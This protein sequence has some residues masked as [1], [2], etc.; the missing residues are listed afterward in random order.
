MKSVVLAAAILCIVAAIAFGVR[1][2]V[3]VNRVSAHAEFEIIQLSSALESYKVD[4]GRYPTDLSTE[5]LNP[6]A[7]YNPAAYAETSAFLYRSLS[8]LD[9]A[10]AAD[11]TASS[12]KNYIPD[13]GGH[14]IRKDKDGVTRIVDPWNNYLGYSTFK[15]AHP[16]SHDGHNPTFDLWSTGGNKNKSNPAQWSKNW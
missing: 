13:F 4:H 14:K 10:D 3:Q 12:R 15:A 9:A 5:Q 1:G 11:G 16:E 7:P 8:G 6:D 2:M